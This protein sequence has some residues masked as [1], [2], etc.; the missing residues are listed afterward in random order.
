M[1]ESGHIVSPPPLGSAA[2]V[3][4]RVPMNHKD[5]QSPAE[6]SRTAPSGLGLYLMSASV[7]LVLL[8]G[9]LF[10]VLMEFNHDIGVIGR[11]RTG[12]SYMHDVKPLLIEMQRVRGRSEIALEGEAA[13]DDPSIERQRRELARQLGVLD[14]DPRSALLGTRAVVE[15]LKEGLLLPPRGAVESFNHYNHLISM[16]N[17]DLVQRA[18]LHSNLILDSQPDTYAL[19]DLMVNRLPRLIEAVGRL[20]GRVSG[21]IARDDTGRADERLTMIGTALVRA[22][23]LELR[24]HWENLV[25]GFPTLKARLHPAIAHADRV[26]DVF[27]RLSTGNM[28]MV[29]TEYFR[30]G[31]RA[32]A[33]WSAVW[34]QAAEALDARLSARINVLRR[35]RVLATAGSALALVP[36]LL[37]VT[38]LYRRNRRAVAALVAR[39]QELERLSLT[40]TLTGLR[41]RRSLDA[42]F[43]RESRRARREGKGF[44]FAMLDVDH[45]KQYNDRYGHHAGDV[46]LKGIAE[47]MRRTLCRGGDFLFRLGGEEFGFCFAAASAEEARV[48]A[49]RVRS[50]IE[51]V[52]LAHEASAVADVVTVSIGTCYWDAAVYWDLDFAIRCAD[53]ALYEAKRAGRNRVALTDLGSLAPPRAK[54]AP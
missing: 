31:T 42:V 37:A 5:Q 27:V 47:A 40:D 17:H 15:G 39:D 23:Q 16:I 49:E 22:E 43:D 20:R 32:I 52:A 46:A 44:A 7:S 11:E 3:L 38:I 13:R 25:S 51:R 10:V 2:N 8:G 35:D 21:S 9:A 14:E 24:E 30:L 4:S 34:D 50:E 28:T 19:V 1:W 12:L 41:N 54:A 29:S 48:A 36:L 18:A 45:F 33:R 6:Q 26:T 53:R